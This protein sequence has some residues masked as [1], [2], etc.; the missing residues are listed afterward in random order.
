MIDDKYVRL[1][2]NRNLASAQRENGYA[3]RREI[4]G[5]LSEYGKDPRRLEPFGFK[6]YSQAEEDGIIE[7]IFRRL[8][9]EKGWFCEIGVQNGLEC[10]SLYLIHKGWNGAWIEGNKNQ[11]EPI[12][13]KFGP[14][15]PS[16]LKLCIG[17]ATVESVNEL[18]DRLTPA[19]REID[20]LSIDID[21]NDIHLL[22]ALRRR[23]KVICIEYNA[24]FPANI[25]KRQVYDTQRFWRGTDYFGASLKALAE[26]ADRMGYGLVGTNITGSNAFF[27]RN[28]LLGQDL[29]CEDRSVERL[30]NPPRYYLIDDHFQYIGHPA[31]FGP[32]ED[33]A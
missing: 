7:E 33:L 28:D 32:Y 13:Q 11:L 21:G 12:Q 18:L 4:A 8:G 5:L 27:V 20:F 31:D 29:F 16:R 9:V 26:A 24:K 15:I 14:I 3:A 2:F 23:P 19:D 22:E 25:V 10:N 6:V 30:Y 17:M 1:F